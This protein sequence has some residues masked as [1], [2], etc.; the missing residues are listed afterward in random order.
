MQRQTVATTSSPYQTAPSVSIKKIFDT[1]TS[2]NQTADDPDGEPGQRKMFWPTTDRGI[3]QYFTWKHHGIDL[4]GT[5]PKS[6]NYAA[7]DGVVIRA[8]KATGYGTLIVIDHG[9]GVTTWYGHSRV[10]YVTV[11]EHVKRGQVISALGNEGW[12]TGPHLHFEVR[13]NGAYQN[14]LNWLR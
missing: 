8:G 3:N 5:I 10:L 13:V 4:H 12:S 1:P 2:P 11:G 14:P 9:H 7:D 6:M